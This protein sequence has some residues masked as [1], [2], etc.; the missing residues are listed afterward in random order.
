VLDS[1]WLDL[2]LGIR[3]LIKHP[4]LT[5]SGGAAIA[6]AVAIATGGFSVIYGNFLASSLPLE[7]GDRIVSVELWDSAAHK[8]ERR[9]LYDYYVWR[10]GLKSVREISAFRTLT[11]NLIAPG[12]PPES[13]RV[14]A[15]TA[16]G[17][18]V[19]RVRP[20]LGRF[21]A[22]DDE[23][24][25]APFVVVIG[26]NVWRNRF[27]SDPAILGRTVQLGATP[28][29]I[30]GVMPKGFAFP[31]NHSFWVPLR[32]GLA[33]PAP[34]KGPELSVFGRLTPG[35][36]LETVQAELSVIGQ[37]TTL[38]FP[39]IYAPIRPQ[40]APYP[41]AILG[42]HGNEDAT[43]LLVMQGLTVS[44]LVLV[45]LNVAVLVYTRTAMRKAEIGLRT[46]LGA[47]RSRIVAQLF[48]EAFVLSV[49]AAMAGV[50]IAAFALRQVTVATQHIASDLPFW[51]TFR[52]SPEAVLYAG[53]LSVLAAVIVSI[54]PALQ[55]TGRRVQTGLRIVGAGDSGMRLGKTWTVLI[56]AQV[57]FA[58]ALLPPAVLSAW[59]STRAGLAGPGFAAEEFLSAKLAMDSMANSGPAASGA[60]GF[61]RYSVRQTE[62]MR[63]LEAE[64]RVSRVTFALAHPGDEPGARIEAQDASAGIHGVR[65]NRVAVNFFRTFDVPI[66][67]GRDF[68]F[69]DIASVSPGEPPQSGAVVVNQSLSQQIFGGN[70]LGRRIRFVD[71]S[72]GTAQANAEP[73]SWYEIVGIVSNF[74]K[75]VS[76]GMRDSELKVYHAITA[77]QVQPAAI[78][79]RMRSGVPASFSQRLQTIAAAVDPELHLRDIRSLD[80]ALRREQWITRLEAAVLLAGTVSVLLLSSAGIYA[81]MSF[82]VSQRRREIG[83]RMALGSSRECILAAVFSRALIQLGA[84]AALGAILAIAFEKASEGSLKQG[85]GLAVL[86]PVVLLI[87]AVG[88]LAALGPA[89][90]SLRIEPTEALR[91]Q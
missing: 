58:V 49:L 76:P 15:M 18:G 46:A 21:L 36:T 35:A 4:G 14:A 54:V 82:T 19:A 41:R 3:M 78:A 44:L 32:T 69:G 67:A 62:L 45:C 22:E 68:E 1:W 2:K 87:M 72:G 53:A 37:R 17:F 56:V 40:V 55:A 20:L 28:H 13:I 43:G 77:G 85:N 23:R 34:L 84:G 7:E 29:S 79:L 38:A 47:S 86:L 52:L 27:A 8:S 90:R 33:P 50:A 51:V 30:V 10:E 11:P 61:D 73:E 31:V 91:E 60:P 66:L 63:R 42:M 64:P 9:S 6:V 88:F 39:K 70:A 12:V 81:L 59:G 26:E 24:A 16:S 48:I 83:I 25:G 75:G 71:V 89:Q 5:L 57:G 65:F 74:P 80:E